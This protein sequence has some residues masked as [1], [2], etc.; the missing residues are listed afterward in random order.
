MRRFVIFGSSNDYLRAS[1]KDVAEVDGATY[2][3][4][5][6]PNSS[7]VSRKIHTAIAVV[8]KSFLRKIWYKKYFPLK[9]NERDEYVFIFFYNWKEIFQNGYID[10]LRKK[11]PNCKCVLYLG[12]INN[13][14]TLNIEEE[15][16]RF[17]HVMVFEKNFAK[18]KD[19]EYYPLVYSDYRKQVNPEEKKIDLLFVGWAKGRYKFLKGIYDYLTKNRVNCQ[20]Y[21]TRLDEEVPSDSGIHVRDWVPYSEYVE[22]LKKAKCLLDIVPPNTDCNTLRVNEALSYKCKILT[23]NEN[24]TSEEFYDA[25]NVSVYKIAEDINIEFLLEEYNNPEYNGYV[26]KTT[27]KALIKHLDKVLYGKG[28]K[29]YE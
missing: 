26:T 20:F 4:G 29:S 16:K 8:G 13:A 1:F 15:K 11:Y 9:Y 19:I 21:L 7:P 23:N 27:P 28:E 25:K 3:A 22:L 12:D 5:F 10:Y 14:R 17:D 24:I 6:L 18:E 2:I